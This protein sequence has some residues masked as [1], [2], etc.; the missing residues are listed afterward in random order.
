MPVRTSVWAL[1]LSCVKRVSRHLLTCRNQRKKYTM[2]VADGIPASYKF[3]LAQ[4]IMAAFEWD[5]PIR[6]EVGH[7]SDAWPCLSSTSRDLSVTPIWSYGRHIYTYMGILWN[8]QNDHIWSPARW[9]IT[10]LLG[11]LVTFFPRHLLSDWICTWDSSALCI[12]SY[13]HRQQCSFDWKRLWTLD[14][15]E[16]I[17]CEL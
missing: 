12:H 15:S 14:R 4:V 5:S 8:L 9:L 10:N 1:R 17:R 6:M 16:S 3:L 2:K 13:P 7:G 11:S